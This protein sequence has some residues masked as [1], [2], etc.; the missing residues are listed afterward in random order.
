MNS[1]ELEMIIGWFENIRNTA[2]K[3]KELNYN[4]NAALNTIF[5]QCKDCI[6][7]INTWMIEKQNPTTKLKTF[8]RLCNEATKRKVA[9]KKMSISDSRYERWRKVCEYKLNQAAT[10]GDTIRGDEAYFSIVS[11]MNVVLNESEET[12]DNT[13]VFDAALNEAKRILIQLNK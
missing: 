3:Y 7:Y 8:M 13:K 4:D 5:V 10:V 1:N 12:D 2:T 9:L 11:A 6:E